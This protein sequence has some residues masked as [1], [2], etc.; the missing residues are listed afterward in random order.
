MTSYKI[1]LELQYIFLAHFVLS[2]G[3]KSCIDTVNELLIRE[4]SKETK[5]GFHFL[6]RQGINFNFPVF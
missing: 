5:I 2:H 1:I 3:T 4:M 6:K